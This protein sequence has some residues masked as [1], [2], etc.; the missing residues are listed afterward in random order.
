MSGNVWEWTLTEYNSRNSD[1]LAN[2]EPR[3]SR[4][5]SWFIYSDGA[6]AAYRYNGDLDDRH[7]DN[8]FRVVV[9]GVSPFLS[10]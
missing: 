8:G 5:G 4:G 10:P 1:D 3:T 6:R 7:N 2:A 9:V